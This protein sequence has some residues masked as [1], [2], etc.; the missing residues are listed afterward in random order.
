MKK[1]VV[2]LSLVF[3]LIACTAEKPAEQTKE[4]IQKIKMEVE[5]M[6]LTSN[7]F[8]QGGAIPKRFSCQGENVNPH[9]AWADVPAGTKSFALICDDPDAPAGTWVHWLV[10]NI[11]ANVKEIRQNSVLGEQVENDF[12][13]E[14]Y[15]GPCPPSGTHRYFFRLYALDVE[16][17]EADNKDDFYSQ[18]EEHAIAKAE[19]MG[20]YKK[21]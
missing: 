1:G 20:T 18:V 7:D 17:L 8:K 16:E 10:K 3:F 4:Q 6:K 15:G 9:L 14:D 13:K 19:L 11:P 5:I 12:G 2:I 21:S